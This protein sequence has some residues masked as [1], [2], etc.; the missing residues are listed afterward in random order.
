M[1]Y[2]GQATTKTK[3]PAFPPLRPD[4]KQVLAAIDILK[5]GGVVAIP[6]DTLYGLAA[7]A[8]IEAAVARVF[9][10]KGRSRGVALPLLLAD[11]SDVSEYAAHVP[12]E[13]WTL[14]NRFWPGPLTI[15]LRKTDAVPDLVSGG[16]DTVALRV[17]D[18]KL[19]RSIVRGLGAPVTGTSANRSGRPGLTTAKA[20]EA[21]FQSEVDLVVD[22]GEAPDGRPSTIVDLSSGTPRMLRHGAVSQK[23]LEE[24]LG[25]RSA[26]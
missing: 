16:K 17:P 9:S 2:C 4:Y 13:A 3:M 21:E 5:K 22:G 10:M 19:V 7:D 24:V 18:H 12:D 1:I 6:T 11:I 25:E 23:D 26:I 8:L 20:V 14:A 15:V